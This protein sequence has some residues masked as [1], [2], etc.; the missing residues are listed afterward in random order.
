[1]GAFLGIDAIFPTLQDAVHRLFITRMRLGSMGPPIKILLQGVAS[2]ASLLLK[3]GD[4]NLRAL[5]GASAVSIRREAY[6]LD[7]I[8]RGRCFIS[9]K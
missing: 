8:R 4:P 9:R 3:G 5:G 6:A 2:S 1:M 7:G